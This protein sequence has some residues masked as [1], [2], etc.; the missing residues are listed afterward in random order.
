MCVLDLYLNDDVESDCYHDSH[1]FG[2]S[3]HP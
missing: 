2:N 3:S 1:N